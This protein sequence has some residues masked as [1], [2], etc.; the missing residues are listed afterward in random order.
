MKSPENSWEINGRVSVGLL[1]ELLSTLR[2]TGELH[3]ELSAGASVP[4]L[5]E[6]ILE[7]QQTKVA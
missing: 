1:D 7:F 3:I 4:S 2:R 6:L 5:A